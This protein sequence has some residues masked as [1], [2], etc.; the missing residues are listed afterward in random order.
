[1]KRG[2][3]F[4]LG[5]TMVFALATAVGAQHTHTLTFDNFSFSYD[6]SIADTVRVT[7]FAGDPLDVMYPGGPQPPDI[8]IE[9]L[10][11]AP[12]P[13]MNDYPAASINVFNT[14]DFANYP[15]FNQEY[16]ALQSILATRP[17]LAQYLTIHENM[18]QNPVLPFLPIMNATQA[19]RAQPVYIDTGTLIGIRYLAVYSQDASLFTQDRVVYTFQGISTDGSTYVS[20]RFQVLAA[21][22][23]TTTPADFDYEAFAASMSPYFAETTAALN[24]SAPTDFTPNLDV[25]DSMVGSFTVGAPSGGISGGEVVTPMPIPTEIPSGSAGVLEGNWTLAQYG[26]PA[27]ALAPVETAVPTIRFE[28]NGVSGNAGC[29]NYS[30]GFS[31]SNNTIEFTEMITTRMACEPERNQLE[32]DFLAALGSATTFSVSGDTLTINYS[33]DH[34]DGTVTGGTLVFTRTA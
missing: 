19:I 1:M 32:T 34:G 31:F 28:A 26:D 2:F 29:N 5:I 21:V 9:F 15:L 30:G 24:E 7:D 6:G 20:A 13:N 3:A 14:A 18:S 33:I 4:L 11:Y 23:P 25:L 12:F 27:D 17:D 16:Q 10:N 8:R 22:L